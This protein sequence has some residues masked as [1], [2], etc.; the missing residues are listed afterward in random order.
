MESSSGGALAQA[1][2]LMMEGNRRRRASGRLRQGGVD[3]AGHNRWME[4]MGKNMVHGRK[5]EEDGE[6]PDQ[7]QE[8]QPL[9]LTEMRWKRSGKRQN[10]E[11]RRD[12]AGRE[13]RKEQGWI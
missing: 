7:T 11:R 8:D 10:E 4:C 6:S 9:V 3:P 2:R 12:R 5:M 13:E 1:E